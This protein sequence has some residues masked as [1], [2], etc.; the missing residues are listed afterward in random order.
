MN[1]Y[2]TIHS[3]YISPTIEVQGVEE[4]NDY[5]TLAYMGQDIIKAIF[6]EDLRTPQF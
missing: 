4:I 6:T 2:K 1:S 5:E 3:T